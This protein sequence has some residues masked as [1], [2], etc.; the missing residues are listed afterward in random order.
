MVDYRLAE[1]EALDDVKEDMEYGSFAKYVSYV[2]K[3]IPDAW[4][5]QKFNKH[6]AEKTTLYYMKSP[7]SPELVEFWKYYDHRLL[8]RAKLEAP[9]VRAYHMGVAVFLR[10]TSVYHPITAFGN[11][12]EQAFK[13]YV[14]ELREKVR[15]K[16]LKG[17]GIELKTARDS[18]ISA[19]RLFADMS[20]L[21]PQ[22]LW[23]M[24]TVLNRMLPNELREYFE[25]GELEELQS[26]FDDM[27]FR[28]KTI[29]LMYDEVLDIDSAMRHCPKT[30][31][32]FAR[33]IT[34]IGFHAGL[35]ISEI[36]RLSA[37]CLVPLKE[38][39]IAEALAYRNAMMLS[40][41]KQENWKNFYWLHYEA[42]KGRGG[43]RQWRKGAP[44]LVSKD[45]ADAIQEAA[46][47]TLD[48]RE[49]SGSE[50]LFLVQ[51][52][53]IR[54]GVASYA[55]MTNYKNSFIREYDLPYYKFHQLRA[56]FASILYDMDVPIE[57]IQK[58]L[59]HLNVDVTGRYIGS[60][61][62]RKARAMQAAKKYG[63]GDVSS[64]PQLKRFG[65]QLLE[66]F[67]HEAWD[68]LDLVSQV[69]MFDYICEHNGLSVNY[70]DH[71]FC[72][73]LIGES[74]WKKIGDVAPCYASGCGDFKPARSAIGFFRELLERRVDDRERYFEIV[75]KF[76]EETIAEAKR[77]QFSS[78]SA[79]IEDLIIGLAR[80]AIE[81]EREDGGA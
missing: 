45:V 69:E 23:V 19:L 41:L 10:K 49:K 8:K 37:D 68:E 62:E 51:Q 25:D 57:M 50:R 4:D 30:D 21:Y 11:G 78:E 43:Q 15:N 33:T 26:Y 67:Q 61:L 14:E 70:M 22:F 17:G 54:I 18:A 7:V 31:H 59:N 52:S 48:L 32:I 64:R 1:E 77:E 72:I 79:S 81:E 56:T 58:Y 53:N 27:Q 60:R 6:E 3:Q 12:Y 55:S 16:I 73:L 24:N 40:P 46:S 34:I 65:S 2:A 29:A 76:D 39:E 38:E 35:R 9:T 13:D 42:A 44:I 20:T 75:A 47:T 63:I 5:I 36:R 71:G 80:E 66:I 28:N 74:C